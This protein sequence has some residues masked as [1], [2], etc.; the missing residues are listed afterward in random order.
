MKRPDIKVIVA[1]DHL[2]FRAG[3]VGMLNSFPG[4]KVVAEAATPKETLHAIEHVEAG[5]LLLDLSMPDVKGVSLIEDAHRAMPNLPILIV[6]MHD[7]TALV[8]QA[9]R[10]GASG[11]VTKNVDPEILSQAVARLAQGGR[12]IAPDIAETL[13]FEPNEQETLPSAG[14]S[15]REMEVLRLIA[16]DGLSLVEIADRLGLSPKTITTHKTNIM[17]KLGVDSNAELVR[18]V[19]ERKLFA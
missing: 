13:A 11:Y 19:I 5:V 15:A 3:L 10:S 18:Y 4:I 17:G 9:L 14:L 6:S 1:D 7:E 12:Y 2:L 16:V 8:R